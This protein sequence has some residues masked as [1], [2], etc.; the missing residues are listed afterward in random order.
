VL[1]ASNSAAPLSTGSTGGVF[2]APGNLSEDDDATVPA[3]PVD[4]AAAAVP[5]GVAPGATDSVPVV[6]D[7]LEVG[8]IKDEKILEL[9]QDQEVAVLPSAAFESTIRLES[10]AVVGLAFALAWEWRGKELQ[11]EIRQRRRQRR[12]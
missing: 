2:T 10:A 12:I 3:A 4:G 8:F 5:Q 6:P 11:A 1:L 7:A 9:G